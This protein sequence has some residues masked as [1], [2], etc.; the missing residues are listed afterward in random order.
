MGEILILGKLSLKV[1]LP[2]LE[3]RN[4]QANYAFHYNSNGGICLVQSAILFHIILFI[5]DVKKVMSCS[6]IPSLTRKCLQA[7]FLH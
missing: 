1:K 7:K 5:L 4:K 3:G 2:K 6:A